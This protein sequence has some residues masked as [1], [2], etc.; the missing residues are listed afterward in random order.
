[1]GRA[2]PGLVDKSEE[3]WEAG[4]A[5]GPSINVRDLGASLAQDLSIKVRGLGGRSLWQTLK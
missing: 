1:M 3:F 4:L 5:Q 2:G